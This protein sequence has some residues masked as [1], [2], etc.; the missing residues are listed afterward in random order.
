MVEGEGRKRFMKV[1]ER[2]MKIFCGGLNMSGGG[3]LS[4][5]SN[6]GIKVCVR[7]NVNRGQPDGMILTA[8]TSVWLPLP[9]HHVFD[10]LRHPNRR[11]QVY[12]HNFWTQIGY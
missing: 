8:A 12:I 7:K 10:F 4:E 3:Q 2:M 5:T 6:N 1:G 9:P 11:P